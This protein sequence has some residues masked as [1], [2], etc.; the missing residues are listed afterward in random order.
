M[1]FA[2]ANDILP[3]QFPYAEMQRIYRE[4]ITEEFPEANPV[5]PMSEEEFR[6]ALD[7]RKI[8]AGRRTA[9]SCAPDQIDAMLATAHS[10]SAALRAEREAAERRID[11]SLERLDQAF[12]TLL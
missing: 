8:V 9:G 11:E 5:L 4:E 3:L 1:G 2:R 6:D 12:A 10:R 7:P